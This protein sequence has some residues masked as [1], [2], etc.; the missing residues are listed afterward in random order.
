MFGFNFTASLV[1]EIETV[2]DP[3]KEGSDEFSQVT[4]DSTLMAV[5]FIRELIEGDEDIDE[6]EFKTRE[7][8][9]IET[10]KKGMGFS[11]DF[12]LSNGLESNSNG[13]SQIDSSSS[14]GLGESVSD[15]SLEDGFEDEALNIATKI[16]K[17]LFLPARGVLFHGHK[18]INLLKKI[19]DLGN[20]QIKARVRDIPDLELISPDNVYVKWEI[21]LETEES[22]S[23]IEDI[24]VFLNEQSK[25]IVEEVDEF[26]EIPEDELD[27]LL[28]NTDEIKE[29][30]L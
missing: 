26:Y 1:H 13:E 17:I 23:A 9:L 20:G 8:E 28:D 30:K 24:F 2:L 12:E 11:V 22:K 18:P 4:V 16:Y 19:L 6:V 14:I 5:D 27:L 7:K 15:S 3:I 25:V 10:I 21:K 29:E